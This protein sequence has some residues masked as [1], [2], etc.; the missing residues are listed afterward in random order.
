MQYSSQ[1]QYYLYRD[2]LNYSA[3]PVYRYV[4]PQLSP[5]Y[6]DLSAWN[7]WSWGVWDGKSASWGANTYSADYLRSTWQYSWPFEDDSLYESNSQPWEN[8]YRRS[9]DY[10]GHSAFETPLQYTDS[11]AN[12]SPVGGTIILGYV[13]EVGNDAVPPPSAQGGAVGDVADPLNAKVN[14]AFDVVPLFS[15]AVNG[16]NRGDFSASIYSMRR[17]AGVNPA[18]LFGSQS[19]IAR[20]MAEDSGWA[21]EVRQARAVFENP[22]ERVVSEA[23]A[24]FMVAALSAALGEPERAK[25]SIA[26][27]RQVGDLHSSTELLRRALDGEDFSAAS[28]WTAG[29]KLR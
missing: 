5:L 14:T 27:A 15:Q 11:G 23:D 17:A 16:A 6:N 25:T 3:A 18:G 9:T 24:A 28:P 26:Q 21:K 2:V 13:P 22:P 7:Q 10:V 8:A 1:D 19:R 4:Q 20:I 29:R 12:V